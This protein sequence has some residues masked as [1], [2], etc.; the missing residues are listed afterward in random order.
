MFSQS[1]QNNG[2]I[3]KKIGRLNKSKD[4]LRGRGVGPKNKFMIIRE[5]FKSMRCRRIYGV[6]EGWMGKIRI[7]DPEADLVPRGTEHVWSENQAKF[8][9][10]EILNHN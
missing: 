7:A 9:P 10:N 3:A 2:E 4:K 5:R 1:I 8:V 6:I